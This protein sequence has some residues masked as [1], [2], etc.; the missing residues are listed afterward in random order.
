[1]I[2][3]SGGLLDKPLRFNLVTKDGE[4]T[5][6]NFYDETGAREADGSWKY[7]VVY[8]KQHDAAF[9]KPVTLQYF[10]IGYAKKMSEYVADDADLSKKVADKEKGYGMLQLDAVIDEYNTWYASK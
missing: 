8:L 1:S 10:G 9:P 3:Y 2:H 5:E 4:I 6:F 7:D